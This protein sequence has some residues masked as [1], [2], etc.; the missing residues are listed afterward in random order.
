M[1]ISDASGLGALLH[2]MLPQ[3]ASLSLGGG[4]GPE[5]S[6]TTL[7][8]LAQAAGGV[9]PLHTLRVDYANLGAL[10][11]ILG[12][13]RKLSLSYFYGD[14]DDETKGAFESLLAHVH[15]LQELEFLRLP[16]PRCAWVS[17]SLQKLSIMSKILSCFPLL[18]RDVLYGDLPALREVQ[19]ELVLLPGLP[20]T[21][22]GAAAIQVLRACLTA[23]RV[24][25]RIRGISLF[26]KHEVRYDDEWEAEF[27]GE[28]HLHASSWL[29][30]LADLFA[31][32]TQAACVERVHL[33][34]WDPRQ[35]HSLDGAICIQGLKSFFPNLSRIESET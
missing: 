12:S 25:F 11:P 17:P 10:A 23:P 2:A 4:C 19:V 27:W 34:Y 5:T 29:Q 14:S 6:T 24:N 16:P 32:R 1:L 26:Y 33:G 15:Q 22:E 20:S 8:E 30:P 28:G 31:D 9:L 3:L 13:L 21:A 18:L 35:I 7:S